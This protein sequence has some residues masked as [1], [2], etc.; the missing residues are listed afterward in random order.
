MTDWRESLERIRSKEIDIAFD[1]YG[2]KAFAN[3]LELGAG[4]GFQSQLLI[5]YAGRLVATELNVE[6]LGTAPHEG[7]EYVVCDAE[8]V[9]ESFPPHSFDL[10]FSSNVFEHLPSPATALAGVRAVLAEDGVVV[11]IMP[12]SLWKLFSLLGFYPNACRLLMRAFR[13]GRLQMLW[14]RYVSRAPGVDDRAL[15]RKGNNLKEVSRRSDR[16]GVFYPE[17]H[18]AYPTHMAEFAAFSK[19]NWERKFVDAGFDVV[20]VKKGPISSG[21]GF[22]FERIK[23][24]IE[25]LGLTTEYIY[26]LRERRF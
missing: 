6:R 24:L 23:R 25:R 19:R 15:K 1:G 2:E 18:G 22:G 14:D 12:N 16:S 26:I 11:L 20:V 8:R 21:Y 7:V 4:S 9:G 17:P 13:E 5:R 3:A 10:V